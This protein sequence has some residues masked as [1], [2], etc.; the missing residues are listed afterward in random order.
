MNPIPVQLWQ[1]SCTNNARQLDP[2]D[3]L[4]IKR[5]IHLPG[6][7]IGGHQHAPLAR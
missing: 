6:K 3:T 2:N 4:H 5:H 1:T 7:I